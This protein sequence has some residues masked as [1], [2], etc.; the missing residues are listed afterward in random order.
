[1]FG[2]AGA[3]LA[4]ELRKLEVHVTI[5]DLGEAETSSRVAAGMITPVTG[6][7][8]K[9]TWRCAELTD[10]AHSVYAEIEAMHHIEIW[11]KW[12]LRRV[13]REEIMSTWFHERLQR[14]EYEPLII[15]EILPGTHD[16]VE[17]PF[18]G[19]EHDGVA[20]VDIPL[21]LDSLQHTFDNA[22]V[23]SKADVTVHCTGY[24][25]LADERWSWLPIEP[26]KGEILDVTIP[27]LF[28]DHVLT[29]GT[30][31]LPVGGE[32]YRIGA[33]HDWDDHDPTPTEAG[34]RLLLDVAQQLVQRTIIVDGHRAA[35][36][37][38]TKFKRPLAGFHPLDPTH[39]IF[40]GLGTKGALQAP[41]AAKQLARH[42][43]LNEPLDQEIDIQ[44]W[45]KP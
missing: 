37:P 25:A 19:F 3:L 39:A 41:W 22:V 40:N 10:A 27:G 30:W 11:K 28:L 6:R 18:G 12:T 38:S 15:K 20:T 4:W 33:T 29:N 1:G 24:I 42:I 13:F 35:I 2:L 23:K 16:G 45:W 36:R 21:M 5:E 26:S 31:L 8:L 34:R 7:R 32:Q 14:G 9:P 44:K 17:Y 43:V